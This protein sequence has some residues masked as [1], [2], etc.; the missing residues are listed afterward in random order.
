MISNHVL[1]DGY[2]IY[3]AGAGSCGSWVQERIDGDWCDTGQWLLGYISAAG[4][5]SPHDL[6]HVDSNAFAVF[7]DNYCEARPLD[8]FASG[9]EILVDALAE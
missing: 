3:G 4:R 6:K 1:A 2:Q 5:F 7:M 9:A 8:D